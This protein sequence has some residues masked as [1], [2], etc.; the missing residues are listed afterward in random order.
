MQIFQKQINKKIEIIIILITFLIAF[1]FII[2]SIKNLKDSFSNLELKPFHKNFFST[3]KQIKKF[4][5]EEDFKAYLQASR[6]EE[7]YNNFSNRGGLVMPARMETEKTMSSPSMMQEGSTAAIPKR[8]SKTNVQV[9]EIDEPDIVKTNGREIYFSPESSWGVVPFFN[10]RDELARSMPKIQLTKVINAFPPANLSFIASDSIIEGGTLLLNKNMLVVFSNQMI[11]GY[12]ILNP[13]S[14]EKKWEIKQEDNVSIVDSRLYKDKIYLVT[15]TQID[16]S[17]PCAIKL[18][19]A[20]KMPLEIKCLDIYHPVLPVP[21]DTTF[22]AMAIDPNSGKI[23]KNVSFVGSADDSIIYMSENGIYITY[24]YN[25]SEI[26]FFSA[27]LKENQDIFP[28]WLIE[29]LKKLENYDIGQQSKIVE[30]QSLLEKY[31]KSLNND[32]RMKIENELSNRMVNYY[33]NHQRELEK[34]GIVKI[35]L[36]KFDINAI[37]N[38]PGHPLNQ[39]ALDEYKNNLRIAVTIGERNRQSGFIPGGGGQETVN[40]VYVLSEDLKI[41]GAVKDLG[42]TERIYSARFIEDRGYLVTFRQTDPFYVL[43]LSSPEKPELKGELKIPGYSSYL[44]PISS[45]IILGIGKENQQVKLSLF[46]VAL[47]ENPKE[48]DKYILDEYWSEALDNHRAFLLDK[49]YNIF[50]LPGSKGGYIFSYENNK[51]KLVKAISQALVKRALFINDYLYIIGD[52]KII[53][54]NEIDWE[55][56]NELDL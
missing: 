12:D 33:K 23:E 9:L 6:S 36:E 37:G 48:I 10:N 14:P 25:E 16:K 47:P 21:V 50:F 13:K 46:D 42:I 52:D 19:T 18:L 35:D 15:K 2:F 32:E 5:S 51:F 56:V 27:F 7:T 49:K 31:Q 39:F 45:D 1:L 53:V 22:V 11:F 40:D 20:E 24:S 8:V 38:V 17:R 54:L 4:S 43:D 29:K 28:G 3:T 55:K 41:I 44:H 34:T 30:F 26:Q